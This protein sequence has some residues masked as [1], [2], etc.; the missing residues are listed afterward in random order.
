MQLKY[1]TLHELD[2]EGNDIV[3]LVGKVTNTGYFEIDKGYGVW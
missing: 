3:S 2:G 1:Y